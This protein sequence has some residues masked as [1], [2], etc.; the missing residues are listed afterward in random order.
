MVVLK[1]FDDWDSLEV[2]SDHTSQYN[3]KKENGLSW[4]ILYYGLC[5]LNSG[6]H[7]GQ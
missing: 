7:Q 5:S 4:Q 3:N 2:I 6:S 1:N